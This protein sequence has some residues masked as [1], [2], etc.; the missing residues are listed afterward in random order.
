MRGMKTIVYSIAKNE[1]K[2]VDSWFE[3]MREADEVLVADTGSTDGTVARLREL[4]ATV[5]QIN[6]DPWRFD[7]AHNA[8]TLFIPRDAEICVCTHLD[9]RFQPGWRTKLEAAWIPGKTNRAR[10]N[11][12]WSFKPDG[13]PFG[14]LRY[15]RIH[16]RA[17]FVWKY[18]VHECLIELP[19]VR[20]QF[21][22]TDVVLN[23]HADDEKPRRY[24]MELLE[25]ALQESPQDS[26]CLFYLAREYGLNRRWHDCIRTFKQFLGVP[27]AIWKYERCQAMCHLGLC[28]FAIGDHDEY[29]TWITRGC[30]ELPHER[31]PWTLLAEAYSVLNNPAGSYF[32]TLEALK[33]TTRSGYFTAFYDAWDAKPYDIGCLAAWKLD[34]RGEALTWA[35]KALEYDPTNE[36]LKDNLERIKSAMASQ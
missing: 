36:S 25:L 24:Y 2:N 10:Y 13:T 30:A 1:I 29:L 16:A 32:A 34:R 18:P 22:E 4:G 35:E 12:N 28:Y 7:V 33:N 31:E 21:C 23:H 5:N 8:S 17:K 20:S 3:S 27:G 11:Y 9:E 6:I 26:R 14:V 19:G 15:D